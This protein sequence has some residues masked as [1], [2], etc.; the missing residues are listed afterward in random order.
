MRA[1]PAAEVRERFLSFF[2]ERGHQRLPSDSLVPAND[3]S[4]LFTGSG[5]NQFKDMF[6]GKGSLPHK[7][8]TTAQ[9][10]LRVP[11]LDEVGKSPRHHTLFEMLGNFS[12]GDYFKAECIPWEWEF[13]RDALGIPD[14]QMVVTVYTDDDEAFEIWRD[15]VG[16]PAEKIFRFGEKENFWP[17][18]VPSKGPN[19]PCGPCSE[20][21]FDHRPGAGLPVHEGLVS[22]PDDRFTEIGNC[23]FTQFDRRADGTLAPLPQRNI[24][25]G[26]GL[27]RITA[28]LAGVE[29]NFETDLFRPYLDHLASRT[30]TPYGRDPERDVR[31]LLPGGGQPR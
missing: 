10:C 17:A 21:Y 30:G 24:D 6:L 2:E 27:E 11:D 13:F 4:L 18:E 19:G 29:T 8:I 31:M 26:L 9:K 14:E 22:L 25:V 5:M 20:I 7:R 23:V 16:L 15:Q 12:F 3:P 28:V 1:V